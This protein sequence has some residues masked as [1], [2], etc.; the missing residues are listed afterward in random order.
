MR[1]EKCGIC[2]GGKCCAW[3]TWNFWLGVIFGAVLGYL[4]AL[5]TL[6]FFFR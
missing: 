3:H 5:Y 1:F 4:F 2:G 6:T